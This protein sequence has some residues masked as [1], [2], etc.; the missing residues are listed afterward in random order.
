MCIVVPGS[1]DADGWTGKP[2][3]AL[4]AGSYDAWVVAEDVAAN[5][6]RSDTVTFT[7][8]A[9]TPSPDASPSPQDA[10][11]FVSPPA[12]Q[13]SSRTSGPNSSLLM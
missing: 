9:Q 10:F 13:R 8:G 2:P 6:S 11:Q 4:D 7:V 12:P 5:R 1:R 3:Q